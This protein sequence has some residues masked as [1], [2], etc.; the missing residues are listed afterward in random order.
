MVRTTS[1]DYRRRKYVIEPIVAHEDHPEGRLY[2]VRWYGNGPAIGTNGAPSSQLYPPL[3][4]PHCTTLC[5]DGLYEE[6]RRGCVEAIKLG[7]RG[8]AITVLLQNLIHALLTVVPQV[9]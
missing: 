8:E 1:T 4:P 5:R 9:V 3:L 7:S 6:G 2:Q